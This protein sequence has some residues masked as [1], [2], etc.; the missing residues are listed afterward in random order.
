MRTEVGWG[1]SIGAVSPGSWNCVP[2]PLSQSAGKSPA[3]S[4]EPGISGRDSQVSLDLRHCSCALNSLSSL[5]EVQH[6]L[7]TG[8]LSDT[9]SSRSELRVQASPCRKVL[10]SLLS[11]GQSRDRGRSQLICALPFSFFI[12]EAGFE[13]MQPESRVG[14]NLWSTIFCP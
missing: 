4:T 5:R 1:R 7:S 8:C 6:V 11:R 12:A 3:R 13:L 10:S 14:S 9:L 2:E